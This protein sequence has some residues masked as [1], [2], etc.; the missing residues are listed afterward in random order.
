MDVACLEL[1]IRKHEVKGHTWKL[2]HLQKTFYI[3]LLTIPESQ[4]S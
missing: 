1:A 4:N 3:F 2:S